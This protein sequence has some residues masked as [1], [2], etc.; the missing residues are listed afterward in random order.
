MTNF[1][2][3]F[4]ALRK[5]RRDAKNINF[6]ENIWEQQKTI[7][8]RENKLEQEKKEIQNE[9]NKIKLPSWSK[10]LLIFLFLNFTFLELFIG[11]VTLQSFTLAFTIGIMP[12]FTPLV[13]LIGL[14]AGETISYGVYCAKSKAENVQGGLVRDLAMKELEYKYQNNNNE[15]QE[16]DAKG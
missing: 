16:E 9:R 1:F 10:M 3:R 5:L 6:K 13:T 15:K 12:D 8:L 7:K 4:F 14:V 2:T 11:Y